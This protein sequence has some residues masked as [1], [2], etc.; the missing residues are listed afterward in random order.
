MD[1]LKKLSTPKNYSKFDHKIV[2]KEFLL[3]KFYDSTITSLVSPAC[4][5]KHHNIKKFPSKSHP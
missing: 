3:G 2:D 1:E 4:K 5:S